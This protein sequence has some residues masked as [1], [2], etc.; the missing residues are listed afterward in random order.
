MRQTKFSNSLCV[1]P[2]TRNM[3]LEDACGVVCT[4]FKI[5]LLYILK[6]CVVIN[7]NLLQMKLEQYSRLGT[8]VFVLLKL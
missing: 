4:I 5:H 7:N 6:L 3:F 1:L 8:G 2:K